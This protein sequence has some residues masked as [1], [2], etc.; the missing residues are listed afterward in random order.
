[1]SNEIVTKAP[2]LSAAQRQANR[3]ERLAH[4]VQAGRVARYQVQSFEAL[5]TEAAADGIQWAAELRAATV[6]GSLEE[7]NQFLK[8]QILHGRQERSA[9]RQEAQQTALPIKPARDPLK[10]AR[11]A[12]QELQDIGNSL[13]PVPATTGKSVARKSRK[14]AV[15]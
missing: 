5:L 11:A 7:V 14:R 8:A 6:S 13:A 3:R 4:D 2:A 15:K 10:R 1:M 9:I 12:V